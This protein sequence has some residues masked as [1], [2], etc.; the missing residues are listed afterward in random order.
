LSVIPS[1]GP[2]ASSEDGVR[3]RAAVTAGGFATVW[4]AVRDVA[5]MAVSSIASAK[6]RNAM[7]VVARGTRVLTTNLLA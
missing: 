1:L 6:L 7:A 5:A 3:G 4:C 2:G